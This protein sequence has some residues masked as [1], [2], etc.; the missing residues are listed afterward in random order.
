ML[1]AKLNDADRIDWSRAAI[2]SSHVRA[3]GGRQDRPEPGRPLP[4]IEV[5]LVDA[6][7]PVRGRRGRPRRRPKRLFGDRATTHARVRRVAPP[8]LQ[9]GIA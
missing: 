9:A 8:A 6:I 4:D 1:L 5:P 2:D 7:P 3:F